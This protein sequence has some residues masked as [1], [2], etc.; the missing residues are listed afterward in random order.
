MKLPTTPTLRKVRPLG[1]DALQMRMSL[2]TYVLFGL[3]FACY[4]AT[5]R[6]IWKL[7]AESRREFPEGRFNRFWWIPAWRVHRRLFPGSPL[8]RKIVVRFGLTFALLLI[9]TANM[10]MGIL[11]RSAN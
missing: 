4:V 5:V 10:A 11:Q 8:R 3:A 7:V 1:Y 2:I 6:S 9:A